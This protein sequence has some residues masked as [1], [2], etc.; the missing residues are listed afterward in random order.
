M[1]LNSEITSA[2]K[3]S[4]P[5]KYAIVKNAQ[6]VKS[7]PDDKNGPLHQRWIM[8]IENGITITVFHNVDIAERVPVTVGSRLTVAGELEYGDKWKD[9]IM[10]WTHDDP[11]NRRKAGYVILN[12]TTYGHATGP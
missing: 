12:G 3:N 8:E 5:L 10:H 4:A 9:P 6:V 2:I 7:L 1:N 11:Q